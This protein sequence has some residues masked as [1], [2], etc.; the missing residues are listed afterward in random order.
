MPTPYILAVVKPHL[1]STEKLDTI[2]LLAPKPLLAL[3]FHYQPMQLRYSK[4]F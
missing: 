1:I 2:L 4:I 3:I